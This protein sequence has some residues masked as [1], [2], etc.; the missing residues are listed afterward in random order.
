MR[1]QSPRFFQYAD[2]RSPVPFPGHRARSADLSGDSH[3][4]IGPG[5]RKPPTLIDHYI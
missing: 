1:D 2:S 5:G 3:P 4:L